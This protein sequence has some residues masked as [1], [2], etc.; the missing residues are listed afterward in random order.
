MARYLVAAAGALI[1]F[2][3]GGFAGLALGWSIGSVVGTLLFPPKGPEGPRLDDLRV[4]ISSYGAAIPWG[5][6]WI[7]CTG[8]MFWSTDLVEQRH[9]ESSKG[10][11]KVVTYNYFANCSLLFCEGPGD[12]I[13]IRADGKLIWSRNHLT[14]EVRSKYAKTISWQPGTEDDL[15]PSMHEIYKGAGNVPGYKGVFKLHFHMFPLEDFGQ[16]IPNFSVVLFVGDPC[17]STDKMVTMDYTTGVDQFRLIE[18]IDWDNRKAYTTTFNHDI[19]TGLLLKVIT[20]TGEDTGLAETDTISIGTL[21][22]FGFDLENGQLMPALNRM[23]AINYVG[24]G[25][26]N[27]FD[28]V[29]IDLTSGAIVG[30]SGLV[31]STLEATVMFGE[32]VA[33]GNHFTILTR[34]NPSQTTYRVI[35]SDADVTDTLFRGS[36]DE[37][38]VGIVQG[39]ASGSSRVLFLLCDD[40]YVAHEFRVYKVTLDNAGNLGSFNLFKTVPKIDFG[41]D[42]A[43][44]TYLAADNSLVF[45]HATPF[46]VD[47]KSTIVTKWH[48][49]TGTQMYT[50][51]SEASHTGSYLGIQSFN[52]QARHPVT[53]IYAESDGNK[54]FYVRVATG[55]ARECFTDGP[56][57]YGGAVWDDVNDRFFGSQIRDLDADPFERLEFMKFYTNTNSDG[58]LLKTIVRD[59]CV[60]CEM[61]E[62]DDFDVS[63][64]G[65]QIVH[66]YV[67]A[68]QMTGRQII[69]PLQQFY[70]FDAIETEGTLR[71]QYRKDAVVIPVLTSDLGTV[72]IGDSRAPRLVETRT[73]EIELP[74]KLTLNF[75]D[76]AYDYQQSSQYATRHRSTQF[77]N[78]ESSVDVP[79]SATAD[80]A[81]QI[82]EKLL[83]QAWSAR[84]SYELQLPRKYLFMDAGDVLMTD[85]NGVRINCYIT[86]IDIGADNLMKVKGYSYVAE[87]YVNSDSVGA[88][89]PTPVHDIPVIS[90]TRLVPID[91]PLLIESFDAESGFVVAAEGQDQSGSY[92]GG[93]LWKSSDGENFVQVAA[94]YNEAVIGVAST[95]LPDHPHTHTDWTNT[96]RVTINRG[97]LSSATY[98]GMMN[99][100]NF[101]MLGAELC[102]FM[103][104]TMVS[105]GVYDL[106]GLRRGVKGTGWASAGHA[107]DDIFVYLSVDNIYEVSVPSAEVGVA[108]TYR[109]VTNGMALDEAEPEEISF[110]CTNVHMKPLA[111]AHV[112]GSRAGDDLTVTWVPCARKNVEIKDSIEVVLDE[113]IEQYRVRF[114]DGPTQVREVITTTPTCAYSGADQ[115]TDFGSPQAAID[116]TVEQFSNRVGYGY[117]TERTL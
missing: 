50:A 39:Y 104:A 59:A 67:A 52:V 51:T 32:Y 28:V 86:A 70:F 60:R 102:Q 106:T 85:A 34:S 23:I 12:P 3:I 49:D 62:G 14:N 90:P 33:G 16:R 75:N 112:H 115:T 105:A 100:A 113:P 19:P 98:R 24:S 116:T 4:Q 36:E 2:L 61:V 117:A 65:D 95:V 63:P 89:A 42:E 35:N 97:I 5:R 37:A 93:T 111:P 87:I 88:S 20:W 45:M 17:F 10:G 94:M 29:A 30:D 44:I 26:Y 53:D 43:G 58:V 99:G 72:A 109:P 54:V 107:V 21:P 78:V 13:E 6:G 101:F 80:T 74:A 84:T 22:N 71:F 110:I 64:L 8:N 46:D 9:E 66:G 83:Y 55:E 81:K 114:Y 56:G 15:P 57:L 103:I 69:E 25:V 82:V 40:F 76:P 92:P 79:L 73:Q 31:T 41:D 96:L 48:A 1:G 18:T 27:D 47:T 7:R 68:K 11:P 77:S 91:G 108:R 38:I